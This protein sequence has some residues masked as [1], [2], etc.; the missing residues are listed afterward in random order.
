MPRR[1]QPL[2]SGNYY[3]VYNRGL[4]KE[5]IFFE[6]E[7]FDF[8]IRRLRDILTPDVVTMV[9]YCLMPNHYHTLVQLHTD[10]F[11]TFMQRLH[12]SFANAMNKRYQRVGPLFQGRF[13][14]RHVEKD[15][16]LLHLSRYIHLNPVHAGLVTKA[17][18]WGTPAIAISSDFGDLHL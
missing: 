2:A 14:A 9:S 3:H 8:F 12:M 11:S 16:Y 10:A 17:E 15:S 13:Q 18:E 5:P 6:P 7:N 1:E 4:A